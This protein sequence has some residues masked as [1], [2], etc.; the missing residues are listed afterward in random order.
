MFHI[1]RRGLGAEPF[2]QQPGIAAGLL[3]QLFG[4]DELTV[5]HGPVQ[6]QFIAED[7][8]GE[9]GGG[10]HVVDQLSHEVVQLG[11]VHCVFSCKKSNVNGVVTPGDDLGPFLVGHPLSL[12]Q[13]AWPDARSRRALLTFD[14]IS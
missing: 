7:Q 9:Q 13:R 10:A 3:R 4:A 14:W 6:A 12:V 5:G 11:F 8:V 2:A 1:A